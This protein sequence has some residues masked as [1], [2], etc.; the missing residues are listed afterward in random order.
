M[1]LRLCLVS[2]CMLS[3]VGCGFFSDPGAGTQTFYVEAVAESD[4]SSDGTFLQVFT[5]QGSNSGDIVTDAT[6]ELIGEKGTSHVLPWVGV[7]GIGV[8]RKNNIIWEAGWRLRITRG[9]DRVEAYLNAPGVTSILEPA[10]G[11][12]FNRADGRPLVVR[13]KDESGHGAQT[14]SVDTA[15]A[16]Y[17]IARA[18]DPGLVQLEASRLVASTDERITIKRTSEVKLNGGV[19]G[20]FFKAT[21]KAEVRLV[22]Q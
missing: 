1:H 13:W 7:F 6:V 11:A 2:L 4:G 19:V 9:S 8:Y 20:S 15:R 21:T 14:F 3:L 10:A 16:D 22:V 5:R 12:T 17:S 18:E